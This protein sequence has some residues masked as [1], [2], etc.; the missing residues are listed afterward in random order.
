MEFGKGQKTEGR[1]KPKSKS[2]LIS[3]LIRER[4]VERVNDELEPILDANL[5]MAKG[6][7]VMFSKHKVKDKDGRISR[8]GKYYI[9]SD[10]SEMLIL[11]NEEDPDDNF[12]DMR[13]IPPSIKS[14]GYL[15]DQ[16]AGKAKQ[17]IDTPGL[18]ESLVELIERLNKE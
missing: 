8:N 7:N 1:G 4:I 11:L 18:T 2:S 15:L 13:T 16:A 5:E 14:A 9:V 6:A 3:Q 17:T 10:P 12:Y